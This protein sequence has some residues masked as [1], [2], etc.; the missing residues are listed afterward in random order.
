M[1]SKHKQ[2]DIMAINANSD[3]FRRRMG[4]SSAGMCEYE[5]KGK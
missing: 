4:A 5:G 3:K 2:C 1:F